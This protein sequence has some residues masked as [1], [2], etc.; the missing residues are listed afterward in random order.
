MIFYHDIH[1]EKRYTDMSTPIE[2]FEKHI[3]II[4]E[5]GYKIVSEIT[6]KH[7][8]IEICFDDAF[9]GIY[10]N[11]EFFKKKNRARSDVLV[12]RPPG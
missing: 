11:I 3:Q 9:L 8:Q 10:Q 4:H 12:E 5:S 7:G 6:Q 2:L 1:A